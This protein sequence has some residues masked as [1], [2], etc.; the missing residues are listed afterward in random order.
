MNISQNDEAAR[1]KSQQ[2]VKTNQPSETAF[3][4]AREILAGPVR[5][6][7][8]AHNL[9]LASQNHGE[10]LVALSRRLRVSGR[11]REIAIR[12]LA[13]NLRDVFGVGRT[14]SGEDYKREGLQAIMMQ[15][16]QLWR[17]ANNPKHVSRVQPLA[18]FNGGDLS[19][20]TAGELLGPNGSF[21]CK[22]KER[23]A[24]AGYI[25]GDEVVLSRL[26][27]ALHPNKLD[28][29]A[30]EKNE[31][32]QRRKALKILK[33]RGPKSFDKGYCRSLGDAYFVA[34]CPKGAI[35]A[36]TNLQDFE[37]LCKALGIS[38]TQP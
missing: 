1:S 15:A 9:L 14:G 21:N 12:V 10:A 8:D 27:A 23:C 26:I 4:A 31:N 6:I 16:A 7:C 38:V 18:C 29:D 22:Q 17:R 24:A 30:K 32:S 13:E 36:T 20:G 25:H 34:L 28:N 5:Y 11:S 3:Y 35:L 37:P 19:C 2:F 33:D